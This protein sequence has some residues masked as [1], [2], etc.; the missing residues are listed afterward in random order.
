MF[1]FLLPYSSFNHIA[2]SDNITKHQGHAFI[3]NRTQNTGAKGV[4]S[5]LQHSLEVSPSEPKILCLVVGGENQ[6]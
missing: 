2:N 6:I 5:P 3:S 4:A 1:N